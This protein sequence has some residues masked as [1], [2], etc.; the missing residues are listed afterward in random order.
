MK[1]PKTAV[2][3]SFE[4]AIARLEEITDKMESSETGLDDKLKLF[5]EGQKLL[6][7]CRDRLETVE[8]KVEILV[9]GGNGDVSAEPFG[10]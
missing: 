10:E 9:K 2:P 5:E 7:V 1:E 6:K 8:R 3:V 4:T